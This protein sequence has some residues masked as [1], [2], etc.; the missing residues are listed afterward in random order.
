MIQRENHLK[1]LPGIRGIDLESIREQAGKIFGNEAE[2]GV[3]LG[4][5]HNKVNPTFHY[6]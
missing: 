1:Y 5:L 2:G 6:F 3:V 4:L